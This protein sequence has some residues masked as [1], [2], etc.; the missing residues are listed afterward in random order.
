MTTSN[1]MNFPIYM[2]VNFLENAFSVDEIISRCADAGYDGIE[3]R[4]F[5]LKEEKSTEE[6]LDYVYKLTEKCQ[7]KVTFGC[8][9]D[10]VNPDLAARE[11]SM[12]KFKLIIDFAANHDIAVLNVFGSSIVNPDLRYMDF[13]GNGSAFATQEQWK[14]TVEYFQQAGDFAG[15]R[16]VELCFETHNCYIHDIGEAT[17]RFLKE[18]DRPYV[19]ANLDF[20]NIY[21]HKKNKGLQEEFDLIADRLGYVHLKNLCKAHGGE[22]NDFWCTSLRSGDINNYQLMKMIIASG[23]NGIITI[24]NTMPGDKREY[25]GEDLDYLR[26]ILHDFK[27]ES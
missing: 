6:Y 16:E 18:I 9:N 25:M 7:L 14:T 15:E 2:H 5:D 4:G 19:K 1:D 11:A 12:E 3:L 20:G 23:Y 21:L 10:T 27:N 17:S 13:H 24:E 8:P 26:N 22:S